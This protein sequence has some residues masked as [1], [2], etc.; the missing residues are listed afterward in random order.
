[1][2]TQ[3]RSASRCGRASP[4]QRTRAEALIGSH[5][6]I[7]T[8]FFDVD[9]SRSIPPRRRPQASQL[10]KLLEKPDRGFDAVVVG[11]PQRVFYD[12]C[13]GRAGDQFFGRAG[14][15][16]FGGV[17]RV[18]NFVLAKA[19]SVSVMRSSTSRAR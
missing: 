3:N 2:R 1:M 12:V 5:G 18:S 15:G 11:E 16:R 9:K 10:L 7:V 13:G 6:R 4:W 19:R 8:E 17:V 14:I